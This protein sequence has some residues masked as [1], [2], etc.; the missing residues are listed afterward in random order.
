MQTS[1]IPTVCA[2]RP[3]ISVR[4]EHALAHAHMSA[5]A[6]ERLRRRQREDDGRAV[7]EHG[8]KRDD[9]LGGATGPTMIVP[10]PK[11]GKRPCS[12]ISEHSEVCEKLSNVRV[13]RWPSSST[14]QSRPEV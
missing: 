13:G 6:G 11:E 7:R 1:E 10:L 4:E 14:P 8:G 9:A 2:R 3:R 12:I 5:G